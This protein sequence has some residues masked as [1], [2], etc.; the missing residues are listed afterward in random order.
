MARW[1]ANANC[2]LA[3]VPSG[4]TFAAQPYALNMP[5]NGDYV[6][7]L[8]T[9]TTS[10]YS[11]IDSSGRWTRKQAIY[12][13]LKL[14]TALRN[15]DTFIA[16]FYDSCFAGNIGQ[17]DRVLQELV[18]D[19]KLGRGIAED[20][21][22][23]LSTMTTCCAPEETLR[24]ICLML[25]ENVADSLELTSQQIE[26]LRDMAQLCPYIEGPGVY[27]ARALL[28]G[29]DTIPQNYYNFCEI[30]NEPGTGKWDGDYTLPI[31]A[32][33]ISEEIEI[34]VYPNPATNEIYI[35][36]IA[37]QALSGIVNMYDVVGN[38]VLNQ[39][40][41]YSLTKINVEKLNSGVYL[42]KV[43]IGAKFWKDRIVLIK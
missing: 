16:A 2:K 27:M 43:T 37:D 12:Q 7:A 13:V 28:V 14:D 8:L 36:V 4:K 10:L 39:T 11:A 41:N 40:I 3:D 42:Y 22:D 32:T 19:D 15:S 34:I 30:D 38:E 1:K 29:V 33:Q 5:L 6:I 20:Y 31:T 18:Y 21:A 25:C 35:K 17:L 9:D 23:T 26:D 24:I